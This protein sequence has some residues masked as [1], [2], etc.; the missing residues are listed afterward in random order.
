MVEILSQDTEEQ[1]K[2]AYEK[3]KA[4]W[5][6]KVIDDVSTVY[7]ELTDWTSVEKAEML[8][9]FIRDEKKKMPMGYRI[10]LLSQQ[11]GDYYCGNFF[12]LKATGTKRIIRR[13]CKLSAEAIKFYENK[14]S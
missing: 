3:F 7:E 9:P 5:A 10:W 12:D 14:P 11:K 13:E 6:G 1:L 8:I 2:Q 4:V